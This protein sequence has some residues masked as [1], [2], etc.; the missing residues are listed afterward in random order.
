MQGRRRQVARAALLAALA[1]VCVAGAAAAQ[2]YFREGSFATRYAPPVMPDSSF[3]ICRLAYQQVRGEP[4][5][6]GWQ[7]DY[8][9]AEINL[10]TRLS[11]LTKTRISRD[12]NGD[13]NYHVVRLTDDTVFNTTRSSTARSSS[14]P[15]PAPSASP[16]RRRPG[17]ASTC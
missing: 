13:P 14:P 4:S 12:G 2:R 6:I 17:S 15:T 10:M 11:E 1:V 8:P 16:M 9:F 7:T 3:V 5:G